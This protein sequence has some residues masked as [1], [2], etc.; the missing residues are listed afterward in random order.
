M[1]IRWL[2]NRVIPWHLRRSMYKELSS[3]IIKI[4]RRQRIQKVNS[5]FEKFATKK[6]A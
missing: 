2:K 4:K 1:K 3:Y 5:R 6:G